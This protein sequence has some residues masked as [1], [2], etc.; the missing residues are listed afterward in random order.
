MTEEPLPLELPDELSDEAIAGLLECLYE[1]ARCLEN[2]YF[3]QLHRYYHP[4]D[5]RQQRLWTD[6]ETAF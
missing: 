3:A 4:E 5:P 2:R 6:E 1:F